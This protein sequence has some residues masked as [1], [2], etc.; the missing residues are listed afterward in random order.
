MA[1][2]GTS[3]EH[4]VSQLLTWS[5]TERVL[6]SLPASNT[7]PDIS[8]PGMKGRGGLTWYSPCS[9]SRNTMIVCIEGHQQ[10]STDSIA[11]S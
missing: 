10:A 3:H 2:T 5:P 7:S 4:S 1:R 6:T 9:G 8:D 11:A